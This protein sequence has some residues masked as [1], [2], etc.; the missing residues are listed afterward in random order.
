MILWDSAWQWLEVNYFP[1]IAG[2]LVVLAIFSSTIKGWFTKKKPEKQTTHTPPI[3]LTLDSQFPQMQMPTASVQ[4]H[5]DKAVK[6]I[7]HL[8]KENEKVANQEVLLDESY[9]F[10]KVE[11]QNK[12]RIISLQ[13]Q[14]WL[15]Q[16]NAFEQI[17]ESQIAEEER[18]K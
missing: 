17:I 4:E 5:A 3:P 13:H 10:R 7:A 14:S 15:V 9:R 18:R 16:L 1:V 12:R 6:W 2:V 8:K 11:Y